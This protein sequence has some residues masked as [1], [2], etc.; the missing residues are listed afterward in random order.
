M[1]C[2]KSY[3]NFRKEKKYLTFIQ[4]SV[5]DNGHQ[6]IRMKKNQEHNHIM[7]VGMGRQKWRMNIRIVFMW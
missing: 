5:A 2:K 1:S 4:P 6:D 7:K 3:R